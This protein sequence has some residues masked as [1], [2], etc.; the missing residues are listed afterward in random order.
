MSKC[1]GGRAGDCFITNDCG[2]IDLIEPGDVILADKGF[3][4]TQTQVEN[5]NAIFV[6]L[7]FLHNPQFSAEEVEETYNIASVR[8]HI[9]RIMQRIKDFNIFCKVPIPSFPH[10]DE[11]IFVVCALINLEKSII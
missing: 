2:I 8:I 9:E 10:I 4:T 6:I 7:P 1:Y 3:P 11:I 5:K